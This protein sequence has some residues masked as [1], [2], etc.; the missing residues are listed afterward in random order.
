MY[1]LL[2]RRRLRMALVPW[3]AVLVLAVQQLAAVHPIGHLH[4]QL[5]SHDKPVV[6]ALADACDECIALA[7]AAHGV[8]GDQAQAACGVAPSQVCATPATPIRATA[9]AV[10]R[11]RA[12]PAPV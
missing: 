10:Y 8:A 1:A 6:Q 12:P 3:M 9:L 2:R 4:E 11:S 5:G 7:A